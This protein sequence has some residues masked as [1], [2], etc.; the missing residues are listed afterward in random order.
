MRNSKTEQL[1]QNLVYRRNC[2]MKNLMVYI[3]EHCYSAF[4]DIVLFS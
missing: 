4:S 2:V 1:V 3:V